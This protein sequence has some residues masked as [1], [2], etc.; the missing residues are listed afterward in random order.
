MVDEAGLAC[1][2]HVVGA[3]APFDG[4]A[5]FVAFAEKPGGAR[6]EWHERRKKP[7]LLFSARCMQ[8][9]RTH[10]CTHELRSFSATYA[11]QAAKAIYSS[12]VPAMCSMSGSSPVL[13]SSGDW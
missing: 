7:P 4:L 6:A 3:C 5:E 11:A 10:D 8:R 2:G 13:S 1:F 9:L 12:P